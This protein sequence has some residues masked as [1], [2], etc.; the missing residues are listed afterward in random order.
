MDRHLTT[1]SLEE[2]LPTA[3][4]IT[5]HGLNIWGINPGEERRFLFSRPAPDHTQTPLKWVHGLF[6]GAKWPE[7]GTNHPTPSS[8]EVRTEYSIPLLHLCGFMVCYRE[9]FTFN[10]MKSTFILIQN[11]IPYSVQNELKTQ[12]PIVTPT[13][14]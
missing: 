5:H 9:N 2:T 7:H 3:K 14:K 1:M 8:T 4:K 13:S 12:Q 11:S 10:A 6:P